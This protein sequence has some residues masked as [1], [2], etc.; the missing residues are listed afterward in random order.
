M[1][2][3]NFIDLTGARFGR[4]LV[5]S[6]AE[7]D[8]DGNARWNCVCDCGTRRVVSAH[9]LRR[10]RSQSC[11]CLQRDIVKRN[12]TKHGCVSAAK[13]SAE[14]K[15]Y[16]VWRSM[17]GRCKTPT[18]Q[19][20][21]DYGGRGIS[22]CKV[23]DDDFSTFYSW[24]IENGYAPGLSLDRIDNNGNYSPSNCRW[25]NHTVQC[26]NTR[27][28]HRIT[29]NGETHTLKEWSDIVG[30]SQETLSGRINRY[31]WSIQ[32]ALTIDVWGAYHGSKEKEN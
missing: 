8:K 17:R 22:V 16:N 3:K 15:L 4:W 26:N 32:D 9:S 1:N 29:F 20:Y 23:W 27:N 25:T 6:R 21:K 12:S 28:N 19:S 18:H 14:Y 2:K 30:I 24:A 11:G 10:G 31:G 13:D 7:N 5:E